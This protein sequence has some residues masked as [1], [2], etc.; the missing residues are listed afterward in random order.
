M[1]SRAQSRGQIASRA[2]VKEMARTLLS[3]RIQFVCIHNS[4]KNN[5]LNRIEVYFSLT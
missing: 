3:V 5:A 4:R 1:D 2:G